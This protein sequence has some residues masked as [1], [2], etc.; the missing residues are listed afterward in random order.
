MLLPVLCAAFP[1]RLELALP[2]L[3]NV[4]FAT[5]RHSLLAKFDAELELLASE[6]R[7]LLPEGQFLSSSETRSKRTLD[8]FVENSGT[9][10][11]AWQEDGLFSDR[12]PSL[13]DG[14][15]ARPDTINARHTF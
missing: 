2:F 9:Y 14:D 8:F 13:G 11:Q 5:V 4:L 6:V 15:L 10:F 7:F 12:S 3:K 1:C